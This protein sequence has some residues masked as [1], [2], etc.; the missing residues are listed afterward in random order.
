[1]AFTEGYRG[2]KAE[3]YHVQIGD[4]YFL[5]DESGNQGEPFRRWTQLPSQVQLAGQFTGGQG[6]GDLS[7]DLVWAIDNFDGEG[8]KVL[9]VGSPDLVRRFYKSEGLDF[10]TKGEFKLNR[11]TTLTRPPTATLPSPTVYQGEADFSTLAGSTTGG[12]GTYDTDRS[13]DAVES[14]AKLASGIT[15]G[16]TAGGTVEVRADFFAYAQDSWGSASIT[17]VQGSSFAVLIPN[18]YGV[19]SGSDFKSVTHNQSQGVGLYRHS[20]AIAAK[21]TITGLTAGQLY[22][23]RSYAYGTVAT[24]MTEAQL[25]IHNDSEFGALNTY[26]SDK[27][28]LPTS[29]AVNA[30][31]T[32]VAPPSGTVVVKYVANHVSYDSSATSSNYV[33]LDKIEYALGNPA[34]ANQA[35]ISVYNTTDS[36]VTVSQTVNINATAQGV[37]VASLTWQAVNGKT[38]EYRFK[39]NTPA[40]S[41]SVSQSSVLWLDKVNSYVLSAAGVTVDCDTI[42]LGL[43]GAVW[44]SA[45]VGSTFVTWTYDFS[46]REWTKRNTVTP[47]ATGTRAVETTDQYEYFLVGTS[48]HRQTTGADSAIITGLGTGPVGMA[49]AQDRIFILREDTTNGVDVDVYGMGG[50]TVLST[51]GVQ[52]A[53]ISPDTTLRQRMCGTP[54]GARFFINHA[55]VNCSIWETDASGEVA[56]TT[57]LAS[58]P[59]GFKA[60]AIAYSDGLTFIA[61]QMTVETGSI[62]K[63]AMW[64][65]DQ[66]ADISFAGFMRPSEL[67]AT[68]PSA[69]Q[70]WE[71]DVYVL[72]GG[73][74]VWRY[75]LLRGGFF[76]EYELTPYDSTKSRGLAVM[77]DHLFVAYAG[78]GGGVFVSGSVLDSAGTSAAYR[79]SGGSASN[80]FVSSQYNMGIPFGSKILN[81]ID[82]ITA[83]MDPDCSVRVEYQVDESGTWVTIGTALPGASSYSFPA[84]TGTS[85]VSFRFLQV[86]AT[87]T[88]DTGTY[89]PIVKA[90][91]IRARP[92]PNGVNGSGGGSK[93]Y[94]DV[95]VRCDDYDAADH[96]AGDTSRGH[97]RRQALYTM[98][99][100]GQRIT[101]WDGY[102]SKRPGEN[103]SYLVQI[104]ALDDRR[105][106]LAESSCMVRC[107][108]LG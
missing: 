10:R 49:I 24:W 55:G 77:A 8:Q 95:I 22:S 45:T 7:D 4:E 67:L 91:V 98:Y 18:T 97:D 20:T 70:V 93:D 29:T 105:T 88:S 52:T 72:E 84:P 51:S 5:L 43:G 11:S 6:E 36:L 81:S 65:I 103:V 21:K 102:S 56:A 40:S 69:I 47:A 33:Y 30:T 64:V 48:V 61:G 58:L 3:G 53:G 9:D 50:G 87:L 63:S 60:T 46:T 80:Q 1:V 17:T 76:L 85:T 14:S 100:Q 39:R 12:A 57:Q 26:V 34:G 83:K 37:Q 71:N 2:D 92:S 15:P 35:T 74:R 82:L 28:I 44:G 108:I 79:P 59:T 62:G 75:N 32:F 41:F 54:T 13:M 78:A 106:K 27:R 68:P 107:Q 66:D 25:S 42:H 90:I 104:V 94:I 96:P 89:T 19:A 23:L 73:K 38:Y 86:R 31:L 99:N 101:L 16:T